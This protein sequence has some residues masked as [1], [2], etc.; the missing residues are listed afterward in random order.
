MSALPKIY[1]NGIDLENNSAHAA[2]GHTNPTPMVGVTAEM[3]NLGSRWGQTKKITLEGQL[4]GVAHTSVG[5]GEPYKCGADLW[6][7]RAQLVSAFRENFRDLA[8]YENGQE[9]LKYENCKVESINFEESTLGQNILGYTIELR[10][11][12]NFSGTYGF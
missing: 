6:E 11:Y 5:Y 10:S 8:I 2:F 1:Y 3:I 12:D 7:E 9:V 4:T